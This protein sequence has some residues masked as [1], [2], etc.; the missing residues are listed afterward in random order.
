VAVYPAPVTIPR[1]T[2]VCILTLHAPAGSTD[3]SLW[4]HYK[5]G[6]REYCGNKFPDGM[7]KNDRLSKNVIT[8]TTKVQLLQQNL[9]LRSRVQQQ[10]HLKAS[11][12]TE[13]V[14]LTAVAITCTMQAEDHDVPISPKEIVEQGLMSQEDWDAVSRNWER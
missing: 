1:Y 2:I 12:S 5:A 13:L 8:P 3:T 9:L 10:Q 7:Q 4:T 14:P 6:A 11:G